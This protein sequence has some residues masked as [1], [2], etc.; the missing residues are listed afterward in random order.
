[1]SSEGSCVPRTV[2]TEAGLKVTRQRIDVLEA[3]VRYRKAFSVSDI[4]QAMTGAPDTA[5]IYRNIML[6]LEKKILRTALSCNGT[7]FY[8]LDCSHNPRHPHFVCEM[9]G[10]VFCLKHIDGVEEQSLLPERGFRVTAM[11]L[12][13]RGL[14]PACNS[15]K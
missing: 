8:E 1:M 14:C 10:R 4:K 7:S 5:T 2:L 3:I 12:E 9:C 11:Q 13:Y 15:K 6:F